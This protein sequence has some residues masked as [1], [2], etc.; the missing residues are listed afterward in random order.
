ME[1]IVNSLDETNK[2]GLHLGSLLDNPSLV[3]LEGDLG[4]GKTTFTKAI[5][6]GLGIT[7]TISSPTFTILKS[8]EGKCTYGW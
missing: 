7:K 2:L 6:K 5:A 3:T 4:A 8:Y 1:I